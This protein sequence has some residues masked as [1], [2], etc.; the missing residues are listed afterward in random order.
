[1]GHKGIQALPFLF[2][3]SGRPACRPVGRERRGRRA[4]GNAATKFRKAVLSGDEALAVHLYESN[5]QFKEAL[6]PNASYGESYQ[7]NTP[8]HYAAR[9]AMSRLL[10][11]AP[12]QMNTLQQAGKQAHT[13]PELHVVDFWE[14]GYLR[15][16]R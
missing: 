9:H 15:V 1:M 4:M 12:G 16:E 6:D 7:H 14:R 2:F 13:Q 3:S 10:R 8:L 5:P 11:S